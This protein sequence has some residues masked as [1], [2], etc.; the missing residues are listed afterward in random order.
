MSFNESLNT[1]SMNL[2]IVIRSLNTLDHLGSKVNDLVVD[3]FSEGP[4]S[5]Q[6]VD[7]H[8]KVGFITSEMSEL[9]EK[10]QGLLKS[11]DQILEKFYFEGGPGPQETIRL[12]KSHEV[13]D[14]LVDRYSE[15]IHFL[16]EVKEINSQLKT[17][18]QINDAESCYQRLLSSQGSK[19]K[20]LFALKDLEKH[21]PKVCDEMPPGFKQRI[22][23][24]RKLIEDNINSLLK[25]SKNSLDLP[26]QDIHHELKDIEQALEEY[27]SIPWETPSDLLNMRQH[28]NALKQEI[29]HTRG[30]VLI[31]FDIHSHRDLKE[32]LQICDQLYEKSNDQLEDNEKALQ[33]FARSTLKPV[34][35]PKRGDCLFVSLEHQIEDLS[36]Q[37]CRLLAVKYLKTH[38]EQYKTTVLHQMIQDFDLQS[39]YEDFL[40]RSGES[41]M[42]KSFGY[43]E[44]E[45]KGADEGFLLELGKKYVDDSLQEE[46]GRQP[47]DFDRYCRL[48]TENMQWGKDIEIEAISNELE[49]PIVVFTGKQ[50]SLEK[51]INESLPGSP[52]FLYHVEGSHFQALGSREI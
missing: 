44:S 23:E 18:C 37:A 7:I 12:V 27:K 46:L 39:D 2:E 30:L 16:R 48:M 47:D 19:E 45:I 52:L 17:E 32:I 43:Q 15:K 8:K 38:K 24:L 42:K 26:L 35:I 49:R 10:V 31:Q 6:M 11:T 36:P 4:S 28:L 3:L 51:V 9:S 21:C 34:E 13:Y 50:F 40:S 29:E 33:H 14:N 22:F 20:I 41:V 5:S 1:V 25:E